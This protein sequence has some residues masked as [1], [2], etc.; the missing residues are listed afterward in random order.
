LGADRGPLA[1]LIAF[2]LPQFHPIPQND[3]W[4]GPG[5]TEWTNVAKARPLFRG[6]VQPHIPA[7]LG[8]YD[9][10]LPETRAAQAELARRYGIEGFCYWHY[11]FAGQRLLERPFNEVLASREPDFPICLGWANQTWTGVWH[12]APN[13]VLIEQTYPGVTDYVNHF[14]ELR[15]AFEDS[16]YIR[17]DGKPLFI[18]YCPWEMPDTWEFTDCWRSMAEKTGLGGMFFVG[19]APEDWIPVEHGFDG[20]FTWRSYISTASA[21]PLAVMLDKIR[22]R[23]RGRVR[24][25]INVRPTVV[26]YRN[27]VER[28]FVREPHRPDRFPVVVPNWDNTPRSGVRGLVFQ[29]STPELFGRYLSEAIHRVASNDEEHRIVFLRSWNE[30]AEGNYVEPDIE[31][32]HRYLQAI[33]QALDSEN[34]RQQSLRGASKGFALQH[35]TGYT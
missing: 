29:G 25:L 31:F 18:V 14:N 34:Q 3:E 8:F 32:G 9:L 33:S 30:W 11:W 27:V 15:P 17:V 1:R 35:Q 7:D 5:F 28:A 10:R 21:H 13:R 16:R 12:G 20:S 23:I 4:W 26:K 19:R 6:H 22:E 2:Y 24:R